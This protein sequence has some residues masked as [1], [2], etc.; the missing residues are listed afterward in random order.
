MQYARKKWHALNLQPFVVSVFTPHLFSA[1]EDLAQGCGASTLALLTGVAPNRIASQ[2]GRP[3]YSDRFMLRFLRARKFRVLRLTPDKLVR[4]EDRVRPDHVLLISQL[5]QPGEGTWGVVFG[6][7]FYHNF[8]AYSLSKFA[9]L[10]KPILSAYLVIHPRW[11]IRRANRKQVKKLRAP[12]P[13]FGLASLRKHSRF[14][15]MRTWS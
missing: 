9:F 5:F 10:N 2:N 1:T 8:I 12:R 14:S 13:G 7:L 3:H 6:H 4:A 15:Q 11:R